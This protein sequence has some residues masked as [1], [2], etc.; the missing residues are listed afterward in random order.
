M[1]EGDVNSTTCFDA[2]AENVNKGFPLEILRDLSGETSPVARLD[3]GAV[4]ILLDL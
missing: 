4:F 1:V 2:A 3:L